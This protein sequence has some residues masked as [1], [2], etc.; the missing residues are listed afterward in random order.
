MSPFAWSALSFF[1]GLILGHWLALG[2][3]KRKE[4]ND[5]AAPIRAWIVRQLANPDTDL[6]SPPSLEQ[7]DALAQR[8][9]WF[10]RKSF[11]RT[12]NEMLSAYQVATTSE[13]GIRTFTRT[14]VGLAALRN[15]R[16]YAKLR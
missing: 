10:Q 15:L 2:R 5:A 14:E 6:W 12:W 3:D 1:L 16:A 9:H 11:L 13:W 7:I 8:L 4:F